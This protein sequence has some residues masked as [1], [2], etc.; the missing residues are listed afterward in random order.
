MDV[1]EHDSHDIAG[2]VS[3][4]VLTVQPHCLTP[5]KRVERVFGAGG[6]LQ[7]PVGVHGIERRFGPA[8]EFAAFA[9]VGGLHRDAVTV[10]VTQHRDHLAG[11]VDLPVSVR[12]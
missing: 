10:D 2:G 9:F 11:D 8:D 4:V 3:A 5:A 6:H 7:H 1:A 12:V